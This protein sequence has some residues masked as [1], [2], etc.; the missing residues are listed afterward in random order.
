MWLSSSCFCEVNLPI[1]AAAFPPEANVVKLLLGPTAQHHARLR[2]VTGG[3]KVPP[4][5]HRG[6]IAGI[7]RECPDQLRMS[8]RY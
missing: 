4:T 6:G 5:R 2:E 1:D 7:N 8:C 3:G